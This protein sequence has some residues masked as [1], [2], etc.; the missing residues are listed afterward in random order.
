M[1]KRGRTYV[2]DTRPA[3]PAAAP[4]AGH[5]SRATGDSF[6]NVAARL[7]FG[8]NN[9]SS[10][11]GYAFNPITRNKLELEYMY[12]G[13]WLVKKAVDCVAD[14]MTRAGIEFNS[15]MD[16]DAV[17]QI[18]AAME[19]VGVWGSLNKAV[20]WS[21]L[22]GGALAVIMIDGQKPETPLRL[23][24]VGKDQFKGLLVLD[25]WLVD[26]SLSDLVTELGPDLGK[27]KYYTVNAAMAG[28]P[29]AKYHHTRCI[30]LEGVELPIIQA[31]GE[32]FWGMSIVEPLFDRLIAFDSATT[33]A[34]QLVYRAHLRTIQIEKFREIIAAGGKSY[35]AM[36]KQ[37]EMIRMFQTN[38]G[39]TVLDATDKFEAHQ[40]TFAGLGDI[41]IR[42]GEQVSG[43]L[44]IPLVRL[45]GQSPAG[46][47]STGESDLRNYYDSIS[48]QQNAR[49][50]RGMRTILEVTS[51][52]EFGVGLDKSTRFKF[53]PLYQ[54][55]AV[56]KA[57]ITSKVTTAVVDA[58]SAGI[59]NRV[60]ALKELR[61]SSDVTGTYSNITDAEIAEAEL[62]PPVPSELDPAEDPLAAL[63]ITPAGGIPGG[64]GA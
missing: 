20:K 48:A 33:G 64:P 7:G 8:A 47:N 60:Q 45:F 41:L 44:E 40:Y 53:T 43:S 49:L 42:F 30:R 19:E 37:I 12:R 63:G 56:E 50:R 29:R 59:L 3:K 1:K 27:P 23:D 61:Q 5:N 14:D 58:Y 46:L 25:R 31:T 6:N 4:G 55:N 51:R 13:S 18:H 2:R 28:V 10:D 26:P 57:E 17:D 15:E 21:R 9:L 11:S 62:E 24:T 36:M 39:M 38:E 16:P 32:N 22:F 35:E 52:S 34:G 54:L